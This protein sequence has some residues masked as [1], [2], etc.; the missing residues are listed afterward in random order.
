MYKTLHKF[1][2]EKLGIDIPINVTNVLFHQ[3]KVKNVVVTGRMDALLLAV[4]NA[5]VKLRGES[6][7]ANLSSKYL[8]VRVKTS[9][10]WISEANVCVGNDVKFWRRVNEQVEDWFPFDPG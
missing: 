5:M 7:V 6:G 10:L 3:D 2:L 9:L 8:W 4:K 1:A